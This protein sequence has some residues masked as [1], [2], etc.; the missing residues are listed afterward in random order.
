VST[1]H[2]FDTESAAYAALDAMHLEKPYTK[3]NIQVVAAYQ[4]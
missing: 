1:A 2:V 4:M 3:G